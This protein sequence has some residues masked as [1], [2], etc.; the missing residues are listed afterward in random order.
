[1][2]RATSVVGKILTFGRH[3]D[4]SP[5]R[6]IDIAPAVDEGL[7]LFSALRPSNIELQADIATNCRPVVADATMIVQIVMNLCTNAYQSM[8]TT[9]GTLQVSLHDL[10]IAENVDGIAAAGSYVE[11][12]VCDSGHGMDEATKERI[13]EPFFTTRDVGE[14]TGLG[15]S[16]VHG[17]AV[18]M[19]ATI[20]VSSEPGEGATFRILMPAATA[21]M[22]TTGATHD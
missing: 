18:S 6:P 5:S 2:R 16:V 4:S 7:R 11:L 8:R 12:T 22:E 13:F 1:V 17:I 15:L 3:F 10:T 21:A 9:G 20:Q 19:G 14:G